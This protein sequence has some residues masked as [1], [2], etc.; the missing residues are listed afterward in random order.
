M[1]VKMT[2]LAAR[3]YL[4]LACSAAPLALVHAQTG[5]AGG[6]QGAAGTGGC[7]G[8]ALFG[9]CGFLSTRSRI[10]SVGAASL[11]S[12]SKGASQS[13]NNVSTV[14]QQRISPRLM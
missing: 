7:E 3:A 10:A 4:V 9:F 5:G 12:R 11:A 8:G 13:P 6:G 2:N 14:G 1:S